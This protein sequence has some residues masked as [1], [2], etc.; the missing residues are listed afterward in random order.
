MASAKLLY[1]LLWHI[2]CVEIVVGRQPALLPLTEY[3]FVS[4]PGKRAVSVTEVN[5]LTR[6]V[7]RESRAVISTG[8][9]EPSGLAVDHDRQRLYVADPKSHKVF[10]YKLY[11][12]GNGL[13]VR[14]DEQYVAVHDV[15]PRWVAVDDKGS[16][17]AT[18][19]G[20]SFIAEVDA[21]ELARLGQQDASIDD[22]RPQFH[23]LYM[24]EKTK[25]V[26]RPGGI[27]VDG[28]NVY[29]GNRARGRPYGSLLSAPEDPE[30]RISKGVPDM[31]QAL[32]KNV[33][34]VYG[35]CASPNVVF[36]TGGSRA[37]Y[38]AKPGSYQARA[39]T[40]VLLDDYA[41]P[42]GCVWD[43]DGTVLLADKGGDAIWSF[44]SSMHGL[45]LVQ[46]TKLFH[47]SDP[48]GVAVYRPALND[49]VGFL[50][51]SA[52]KAG[53]AAASVFAVVVVMFG[54][55]M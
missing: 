53:P 12:D 22:V 36:Y 8:L 14:E 49:Q 51:G 10:M 4:Q 23:K 38:G 54:L 17:F 13:S 29:W 39:S 42:R 25:Q 31:I 43:G 34:K 11:I 6:E 33:D 32:S 16:L 2:V 45:G 44:P 28:N 21:S 9:R 19:E 7:V 15:T 41:A 35:V 1:T 40:T 5:S 26:D 48:Y 30:S 46:A 27:A 52:L 24:N 55:R 47:V 18:D 50:R 37:V 3:V 20:R